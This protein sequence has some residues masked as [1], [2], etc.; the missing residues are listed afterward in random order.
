MQLRRALGLMPLALLLIAWEVAVQLKVYPPVLLP[1]PEKVALVFVNDTATVLDHAL[2]SVGRVL[3]GI[4]L[5]FLVAV[6]LGLM[7]GRYRLLD[8]L[9]DWSIQIFRSVPPISLIPLAI[10]FLGIGD[11]PAIALIFLSGL[12]PLLINTIFGV[13]GI[14]RTL[15]KVARAARAGEFLV[16]KDI[17]LPASLPAI[18]TGL[19]LAVGAGWLTVVTA[20]MIAVKSGLG[21]MILN[22]QLTFRSDLIFAG[23][24]VIGAI[25]L[26][27]D[28]LVRLARSRACRWQ[29]GLTATNE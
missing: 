28:Q 26:L 16:M 4:G 9:T 12:W 2:S 3:V 7:I 22:A 11:K 13:R 27:A 20:E 21:Y 24:I 23:I 17:I 15:I 5:S 6:P 19:R 14:E 1:S 29:E 25:G 8:M 18:F 10:L